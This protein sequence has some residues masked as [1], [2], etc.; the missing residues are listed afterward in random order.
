MLRHWHSQ[1]RRLQ[2]ANRRR[3]LGVIG[4]AQS[5]VEATVQWISG[6]P[7]HLQLMLS[8]AHLAATAPSADCAI[9]GVA[10]VPRLGALIQGAAHG[11]PDIVIQQIHPE[12]LRVLGF[13]EPQL[14]SVVGVSG[15]L[16][17]LPVGVAGLSI[18]CRLGDAFSIDQSGSQAS[19]R[20]L[21]TPEPAAA[22]QEPFVPLVTARAAVIEQAQQ[23]PPAAPPVAPLPAAPP[24]APPPVAPAMPNAAPPPNAAQ[25]H[26]AGLP[27]QADGVPVHPPVPPVLGAVPY[28]E[29]QAPCHVPLQFAPRP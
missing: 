7:Q 21:I 9:Q 1:H 24:V 27:P 18:P 17:S 22:V 16:V 25:P 5:N 13:D 8:G 26:W 10:P 4:N 12:Q 14:D 6:P 28:W 23:N 3:F 19:M 15:E 20:I 2:S 29:C 11:E